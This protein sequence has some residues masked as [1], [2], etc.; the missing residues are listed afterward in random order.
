MTHNGKQLRKP[1]A[2]C[3][4]AVMD[5]RRLTVNQLAYTVGIFPWTSREHSTQWIRNVERFPPDGCNSFWRLMK[6]WPD[7]TCY[8]ANL[9]IFEADQDGF[10]WPFCHSEMS[11]GF[12]T[13]SQRPKRQSMQ[14]KHPG[15]PPPKKAKVVS[16]AGK[17]MASVFWD[18]KG[19]IF[20][21][22]LQK[23]RRI[24]EEYYADLLKQLRKAI[25][26]KRP[27]KLT[28]MVLFHQVNALAHKSVV[29]MAAVHDCGFTLVDHPP[30]SPDLAPSD[31]FLFP[32]MKKHL[33]GQHY[34]S[35]EEVIAAVE[36]FLR[37]QDETFYTTGIQGLQHRWRKCVDRK[38][39][40][41]EK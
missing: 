11:V 29:A 25:K 22:Y 26:A 41:V 6:S 21:D 38:G 18:A 33:A 10:L 9:A 27:G 32:N 5:D 17:V 7:W 13:L 1:S 23:G 37:D 12:I 2:K 36:E 16:S 39:D 8:K 20:I 34:R 30:Y 19:I 40:Y 35:D 15:S 28:K 3:T 24:N 31:Y 14:W 4:E